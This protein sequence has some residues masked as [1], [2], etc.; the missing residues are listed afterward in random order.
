MYLTGG[1]VS[2][3]KGAAVLFS[4]LPTANELLADRGYD[5]TWFRHGLR[6]KGIIACIPSKRNRKKLYP[7]NKRAYKKRIL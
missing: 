1:Q 5:A 7:Y 3:Y 6:E 2:D 4:Q